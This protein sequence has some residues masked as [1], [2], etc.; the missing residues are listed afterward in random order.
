[1]EAGSEV[2]GTGG[3]VRI[4]GVDP[5]LRIT[6]YGV[7]DSNGSHIAYVC[8]GSIRTPTGDL[9]QR[10]EHIHA[11]LLRLV[12]RTQPQ[13]AAIE[14]VFLHRNPESA[15]KLGQARGAAVLAC[16]AGDLTV[17][18][19]A[20]NAI[21]LALT[22]KGHA[23]KRQ[24]Q[25]MIRA[26]LTLTD[27]PSSDAADALAAAICHAHRRLAPGGPSAAAGGGGRR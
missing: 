5:G 19:Y 6:G 13:E 7:I 11:E 27:T 16:R 20:A 15:L 25:Y 9:G 1:M 4:L 10:L 12:E 3:A 17:A 26:L 24:V 22:G 21:K 2:R 8:S 18:E 14:R 23:G